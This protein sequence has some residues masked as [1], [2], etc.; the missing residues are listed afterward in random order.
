MLTA[1]L[2]ALIAQWTGNLPKD[3][4]VVALVA[5]AIGL[6]LLFVGLVTF[7]VE[8]AIRESRWPDG[9]L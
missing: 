1:C 7:L 3:T 4:T 2:C 5:T 6:A 8:Y 9:W